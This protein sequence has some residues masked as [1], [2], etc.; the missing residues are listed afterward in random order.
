MKTGKF[1]LSAAIS[2]AMVFA[3]SALL[4]SACVPK[5]VSKTTF[6]VPIEK[7]KVDLIVKNQTTEAEILEMFG[8]PI[9]KAL[10]GEQ[11]QWMYMY[12]DANSETKVLDSETTMKGRYQKLDVFVKDGIVTNYL[13]SD[14]PMP[15]MQ[16]S[17][18]WQF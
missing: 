5:A 15:T 8:P 16:G 1:T 12:Q 17:G 2:I 7:S 9:N 10:V 4:F 18:G 14:A 11:E 3:F 6:G 13:Y